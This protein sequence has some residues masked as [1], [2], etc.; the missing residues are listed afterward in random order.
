MSPHGDIIKV[1]RHCWR[2]ALSRLVRNVP[3]VNLLEMS[4]FCVVVFRLECALQRS[5][6]VRAKRKCV[7]QP[8]ALRSTGGLEPVASCFY[9]SAATDGLA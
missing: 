6:V 9:N 3:I 5:P 8:E 7:F 2:L 1:A 4:P